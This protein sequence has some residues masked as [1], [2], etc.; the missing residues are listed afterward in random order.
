M[1]FSVL[2]QIS[3]GHVTIKGNLNKNFEVFSPHKSFIFT[4]SFCGSTESI[5]IHLDLYWDE[6]L[7]Y[8]STAQLLLTVRGDIPVRTD[9]KLQY[10]HNKI[11]YCQHE[12]FFDDRWLQFTLLPA[13]AAR[14]PSPLFWDSSCLPLKPGWNYIL[15][16]TTL[17][18]K[19]DL[20]ASCNKL[21]VSFS[22]S[23]RLNVFLS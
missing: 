9:T 17:L 23:I 12:L 3:Q 14:K 11:D 22:F 1:K 2:R 4:I 21:I 10:N 15:G 18:L 7:F 16:V 13:I 19:T 20:D 5:K 6:H 8:V